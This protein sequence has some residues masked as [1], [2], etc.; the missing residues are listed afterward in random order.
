MG[1]LGGDESVTPETQIS[2]KTSSVRPVEKEV[3]KPKK[4]KVPSALLSLRDRMAPFSGNAAGASKVGH[5]KKPPSD[6]S[7]S[8][9]GDSDSSDS[10]S[11]TRQNKFSNK[12][13]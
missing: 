1:S 5:F 13:L 4:Q 3:S 11:T 9:S 2:L 12:K 10:D 7:D 8:S 6:E